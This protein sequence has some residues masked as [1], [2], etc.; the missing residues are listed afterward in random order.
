[1]EVD[2]PKKQTDFWTVH[3]YTFRGSTVHFFTSIPSDHALSFWTVYFDANERLVWLKTLHFPRKITFDK[4]YG[5]SH[6][7]F[8][9][10][11]FSSVTLSNLS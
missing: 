6:I 8:V 10:N 2:G 9:L 5:V 11:A 1:M 7:T 4:T 3:F